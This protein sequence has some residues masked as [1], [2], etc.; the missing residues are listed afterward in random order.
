MGKSHCETN[1][2]AL[3]VFPITCSVISCCYIA[4][5]QAKQA[6][7]EKYDHHRH[8]VILERWANFRCCH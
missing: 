6:P 3:Q 4:T 7:E 5:Q 1:I 8:I 2:S